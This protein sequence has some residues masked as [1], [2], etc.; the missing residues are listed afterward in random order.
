MLQAGGLQTARIHIQGRYIKKELGAGRH[1]VLRQSIDIWKHG[2]NGRQ[3]KIGI[4]D[5]PYRSFGAVT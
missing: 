5:T 1:T 3:G 2:L 4:L